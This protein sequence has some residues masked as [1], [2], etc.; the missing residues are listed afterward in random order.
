M[1]K[2]TTTID[3]PL[4]GGL[5]Q[6][7]A[8]PYVDPTSLL[9]ATNAIW[10]KKDA[11]DK[12]P[13]W[14]GS[15][16]SQY[17]VVPTSLGNTVVPQIQGLLPDI[18][19]GYAPTDGTYVYAEPDANGYA[20]GDFVSPCVGIRQVVSGS[21]NG[22]RNPDVAEWSAG[23]LRVYVWEDADTSYG[24]ASGNQIQ[25]AIVRT[26]DGTKA[27]QGIVNKNAIGYAPKV[28]VLGTVAVCL[29]ADKNQT[30]KIIGSTIDLSTVPTNSTWSAP[31][32]ALTGATAT[33]SSWDAAPMAVQ[34]PTAGGFA[35]G[36]LGVIAVTADSETITLLTFNVLAGAVNI[37][38]SVSLTDAAGT[39][40]GVGVCWPGGTGASTRIWVAYA[41][42]QGGSSPTLVRF[43]S[44]LVAVTS[45]PFANPVLE[46]PASTSNTWLTSSTSTNTY[47][48]YALGICPIVDATTSTPTAGIVVHGYGLNGSACA[49]SYGAIYNTGSF[50]Q[51]YTGQGTQLLSKPF[52]VASADATYGVRMYALCSDLSFQQSAIL[53][54]LEFFGGNGNQIEQNPRPCAIVTPRIANSGF[55]A[56]PGPGPYT[57]GAQRSQYTLTSVTNPFSPSSTLFVAANGITETSNVPTNRAAIGCTFDFAHPARFKGVALGNLTYTAGGTPQ[58]F[59]GL[60]LVESACMT[61]CDNALGIAAAVTSGG[62]LQQGAQYTYSLVPEWRDDRGNVHQGAPS[63]PFVVTVGGSGGAIGKVILTVPCINITKKGL[64]YRA[65]AYGQSQMYLVPYRNAV[66]AFGGSVGANIMSTQLYRLVGDDPGAAYVNNETAASITFSDVAT[67]TSIQNNPPLYTTGGIFE[68]DTPSSFADTCTHNG[69]VYGIGD[70]LRTVWISTQQMDGLPCTFNDSSQ[71]EESSIGDLTAIWSM[72]A[73]LFTASETG[74]TY[75]SGGGPNLINSQNDLSPGANLPCDGGVI[76]PRAVLVTQNG[77]IFRH[78]YGLALLDRSLSVH[79]DFGDPVIDLLNAYPTTT[80][81]LNHPTRPE[82]LVYCTGGPGGG[83]VLCYNDRFGTWSSWTIT[84]ADANGPATPS[85]GAVAGGE[86]IMGTPFGRVRR[87]ALSSDAAQYFDQTPGAPSAWVPLT[88][89]TGW[90][91]A[92]AGMQPFGYARQGMVL[93]QPQDWAD[94]IV[95]VGYDY[96]QTLITPQPWDFSAA[97]ISQLPDVQGSLNSVTRLGLVPPQARCSSFRFSFTD[98]APTLAPLATSGQGARILGLGVA[99][100][101]VP[102][103]NRLP[104]MQGG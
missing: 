57:L 94:M 103:L 99:L 21:P 88:V 86:L 100:D 7:S 23:G 59:D 18:G 89:S 3:I 22:A 62:A 16:T 52:V 19:G 2:Q 9:T 55:A 17:G 48:N 44:Y 61:T 67:D 63:E 32:T 8:A 28:M 5:T 49:I 102:G 91:K 45:G 93:F 30:G 38:G 84:D 72:D 96:S 78:R 82:I 70:D 13:A 95:S 65:A 90:I 11:I 15:A 101:S 39:F 85:C 47:N 1:P 14:I 56:Q 40:N 41:V 46:S 6:R 33:W 77:T 27:A 50:G 83:I 53:C 42:N 98:A 31:V 25:Y 24:A 76:D 43:A 80:A 12:R 74:I 4:S 20:W 54:E 66:V 35:P 29:W 79:S 81:I 75:R 71:F 60:N 68:N 34:N 97:L 10:V 36:Y 64:E 87:E 73:N 51:V 69:R 104:A 92:G 26:S 37:I 58:V